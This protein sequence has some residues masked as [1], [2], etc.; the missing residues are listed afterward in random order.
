M[1]SQQFILVYC[2]DCWDVVIE[3]PQIINSIYDICASSGE[4]NDQNCR[5]YQVRN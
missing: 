1:N 2:W 4:S 5:D 3:Y